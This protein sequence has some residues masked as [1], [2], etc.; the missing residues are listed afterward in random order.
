MINGVGA[1]IGMQYKE[2]DYLYYNRE[3]RFWKAKVG[4]LARMAKTLMPQVSMRSEQG[5]AAGRSVAV[6]RIE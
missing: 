6:E 5:C 3:E 1:L 4:G 2:S